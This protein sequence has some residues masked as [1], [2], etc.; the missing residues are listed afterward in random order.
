M[1]PTELYALSHQL[2][3]LLNHFLQLRAEHG[4][5]VAIKRDMEPIPFFALDDE[6]CRVAELGRLRPR[7]VFS[8]LRDYV[9]HQIPGSRLACALQERGRC[10]CVPQLL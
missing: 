8:R 6:F 7:N 4:S 3:R 1:A 10:V 5:V 9:D 2:L